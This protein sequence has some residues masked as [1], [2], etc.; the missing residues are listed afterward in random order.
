MIGNA[1]KTEISM[2]FHVDKLDLFLFIKKT[3]LN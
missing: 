3:I 1:V 2:Q